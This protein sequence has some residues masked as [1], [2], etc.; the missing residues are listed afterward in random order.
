MTENNPKTESPTALENI[1][2]WRCITGAVISGAI[3]TALYFL[4]TSIAQTFANKPIHSSNPIAQ[5]IGAAVRTL[6]VGMSTLGTGVFA[7]ATLGL[8]ALAVQQAI[9]RL[10]KRPVSPTDL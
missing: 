9:V 8:L 6:V 2:P 3:A 4:T 1:S 7:I 10:T 5:N